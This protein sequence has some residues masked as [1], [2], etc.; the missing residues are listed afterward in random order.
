MLAR[1]D[2][3]PEL[4]ALAVHPHMLRHA[5]GY[6]MSAGRIYR[7]RAAFLGHNRLEKTIRYSRLDPSQ[8]EGMRP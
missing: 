4:E 2:V 5:C 6:D 1:L 7:P 8:F 3:R